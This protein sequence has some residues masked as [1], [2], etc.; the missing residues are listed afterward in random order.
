MDGSGGTETA[1]SYSCQTSPWVGFALRKPIG[2]KL[3]PAETITESTVQ[4]EQTSA[5]KSTVSTEPFSDPYSVS[6]V[7]SVVK[8]RS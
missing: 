4:T 8:R 6:S 5:G 1:G 7:P 2:R 3:Q